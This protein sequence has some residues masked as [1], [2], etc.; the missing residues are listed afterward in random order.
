MM[1]RVRVPVAE[2][3]SNYVSAGRAQRPRLHRGGHTDGPHAGRAR[4][5]NS[6]RRVF[7]YDTFVGQQRQLPLGAALLVQKLERMLITVGGGLVSATWFGSD[8][9]GKLFSDTGKI[10]NM[11]DLAPLGHAG[12]SQIVVSGAILNESDN[13]RRNWKVILDKL[14]MERVFTFDE[15]GHRPIVNTLIVPSIRGTLKCKV[16]HI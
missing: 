1:Y 9:H 3:G 5:F 12:N 11:I 10:Q 14:T 7:D 13:A 6:G 16:I 4:C 8:D 15:F 2:V